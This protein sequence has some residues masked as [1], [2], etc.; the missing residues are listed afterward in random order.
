[1]DKN[2]QNVKIIERKNIWSRISK[3]SFFIYIYIYI[4]DGPVR[5]S[6]IVELFLYCHLKEISTIYNSLSKT[7]YIIAPRRTQDN[8]I[9]CSIENLIICRDSSVELFEPLIL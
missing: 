8:I 6:D 4:Y 9:F 3:I 7:S 2:Q 1:M 5:L